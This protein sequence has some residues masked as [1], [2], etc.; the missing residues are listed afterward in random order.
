MRSLGT[1]R[2]VSFN[3]YCSFPCT[4]VWSVVAETFARLASRDFNL[5]HVSTTGK[6]QL[7]SGLIII[8][9]YLFTSLKSVSQILEDS[10]VPNMIGFWNLGR[11]GRVCCMSSS[12]TVGF[13]FLLLA[14][15]FFAAAI[16]YG[17]ADTAFEFNELAG[18]EIKTHLYR[19]LLYT[20]I[21]G[22]LMTFSGLANIDGLPT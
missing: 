18:F 1:R 11:D 7:L 17:D 6:M 2:M 22:A 5:R 4:R 3:S 19:P 8:G 20:P 14:N 15:V 10:K 9:S 16:S 12:Q 13:V 21:V